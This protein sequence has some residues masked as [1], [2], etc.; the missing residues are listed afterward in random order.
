MSLTIEPS[1]PRLFHDERFLNLWVKDSL[2]HLETLKDIP[3]IVEKNSLKI[4]CDE[5]YG[6]DH[7]RLS[8]DS[9][10]YFGIQFG[11]CLI[12]YT[13]LPFGWKASPFVYQSIGMCVT[14]YLRSLNVMN[15]LYIDDK[16][17][18]TKGGKSQSD[19]ESLAEGMRL[20]YILLELLTRLGYTL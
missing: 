17:A 10:T 16:F 12:T 15:T 1:K 6:Y 2:F 3:R 18:V 13:T 5:K 9:Q 14:S 20:S 19:H 8:E 7:V 4:T 11:G